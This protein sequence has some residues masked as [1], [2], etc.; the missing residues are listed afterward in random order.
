VRGVRRLG[1]DLVNEL[2]DVFVPGQH[3]LWKV[4]PIQLLFREKRQLLTNA[5]LGAFDPVFYLK[6]S[7]S[8]DTY[9][10]GVE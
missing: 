6:K 1:Q 4:K 7:P 10:C 5:V 8:T 3:T 9:R 2:L